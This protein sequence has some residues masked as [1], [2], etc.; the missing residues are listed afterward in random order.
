VAAV[1]TDQQLENPGSLALI[2]MSG[3]AAALT[4]FAHT[5]NIV[6]SA[7]PAPG[8][9]R[10]EYLS[11]I[12]LA[13]LNAAVYLAQAARD[14]ET[15]AVEVFDLPAPTR[16]PVTLRHLPRVAYVFQIYSHQRPTGVD[17]VILTST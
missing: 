15:D 12:R 4:A 14:T 13:G 9:G 17:A 10:S 11:A 7:R 1:V 6:I 16:V 5:H 3:P 8:V 2:D